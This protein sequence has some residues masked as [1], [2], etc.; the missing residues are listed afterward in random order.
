[1]TTLRI[2]AAAFAAALLAFVGPA[3][4]QYPVRPVRIVVTIPPG[5]A[6]DLTARIVGER[7]AAGLGQPVVI[8]NRPGANGNT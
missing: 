5:G 4:A 3:P 6:P 2:A 7:L 8:E 1:M